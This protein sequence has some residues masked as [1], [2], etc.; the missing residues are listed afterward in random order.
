MTRITL[1]GTNGKRHVAVPTQHVATDTLPD[2]KRKAQC[3]AFAIV[4][5]LKPKLAKAGVSDDALWEYVLENHNKTSRAELS[6]VQWVTIAAR[7]D[8]VDKDPH[9][10]TSLCGAIK[11]QIGTC[12]AYREHPNGSFKNVYEGIITDAIRHRCQQHADKSGCIVRLHGA[13][14]QDSVE[15]FNP[16]VFAKD[17]DCPPVAQ[18]SKTLPRR[19]FDVH[20]NGKQTQFIEVQVPDTSDLARWGQRHANETGLEL[21]ITCR[22]GH[23]VLMQFSPMQISHGPNDVTIDGQKWII[24]NQWDNQYHW[25]ILDRTLQ[26][27]IATAENRKDAVNSLVAYITGETTHAAQ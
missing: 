27:H 20:R 22:A 5:N 2:G 3:H 4:R 26:S 21:H 10:F 15:R 12:R 13:D 11:A 8:A 6:E 18:T 17:L 25:V 24:L 19:A 14:G 16:K 7:L 1:H 9:L 23:H